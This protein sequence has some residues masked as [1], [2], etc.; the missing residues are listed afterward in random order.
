M[1]KVIFLRKIKTAIASLN[2]SKVFLWYILISRETSKHC[3]AVTLAD[4][5]RNIGKNFQLAI[6]TSRLNLIDYGN[7]TAQNLGYKNIFSY[8][9]AEISLY[10]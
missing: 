9:F 6:T 7:A 10:L 8:C 1:V 3:L 5:Q 4:V 2:Q